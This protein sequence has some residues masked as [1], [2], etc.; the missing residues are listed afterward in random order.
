ML[1]AGGS[2][3]ASTRRWTAVDN[4]CELPRW[5][6][7]RSRLPERADGA[8]K[9]PISGPGTVALLVLLP[10]PA[11]TRLVA[12]DLRDPCA[13]RASRRGAGLARSARRRS[14]RELPPRHGTRRRRRGGR[15]LEH[16]AEEKHAAHHLLLDRLPHLL[17]EI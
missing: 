16:G 14:Q 7:S 13:R 9:R 4:K 2:S 8:E 10:R 6:T 5:K 11:R 3:I 1:L 12:A 17:E 15:V